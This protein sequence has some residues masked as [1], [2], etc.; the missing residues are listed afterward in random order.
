[1]GELLLKCYLARNND[2]FERPQALIS[3]VCP[4]S[5]TSN[6]TQRCRQAGVCSPGTSYVLEIRQIRLHMTLPTNIR[7]QFALP[8]YWLKNRSFNIHVYIFFPLLKHL[9]GELEV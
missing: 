9:Y 1:M 7:R 6:N 3:R 4:H 8:Y 2:A 5:V